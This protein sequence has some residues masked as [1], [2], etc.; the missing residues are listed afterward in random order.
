MSLIG[1]MRRPAVFKPFLL[2]LTLFILMQS[3]GSFAI[4]F[5]AVNVFKG[6]KHFWP[7]LKKDGMSQRIFKSFFGGQME[8]L[9]SECMLF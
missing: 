6:K 7:I 9:K 8:F 2:L 5:Y 3:C 1:Q 4:I